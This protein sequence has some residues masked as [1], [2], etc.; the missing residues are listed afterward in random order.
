MA[1]LPLLDKLA[2]ALNKLGISTFMKYSKVHNS[3]AI[4]Q[5]MTVG[6]NRSQ[7]CLLYVTDKYL[8]DAYRTMEIQQILSKTKRFSTDMLILLEDEALQGHIPDDLKSFTKTQFSEQLLE[9]ELFT[10]LL[11]DKILTDPSA[12]LS[13]LPKDNI[14]YGSALGYFYGFLRLVL[15]NFRKRLFEDALGNDPA[16]QQNS[17]SKMLI[18]MPE[19][20]FCAI[21]LEWAGLIEHTNK[22][23]V[24][25]AN[26]AGN[27]Q[28]DYKSSLYQI[29]DP[30]NSQLYYFVGELATPLLTMFEMYDFQLAGMTK[31]QLYMERDAFYFALK[32]ILSHPDNR[33]CNNEFRLLYWKD[34]P[35]QCHDI[36]KYVDMENSENGSQLKETYAKELHAFL[37]PVIRDEVAI[38]KKNIGNGFETLDRAFVSRPNRTF[39]PVFVPGHHPGAIYDSL[40]LNS[41]PMGQ[42]SQRQV[43]DHEH[44]QLP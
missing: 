39:Q 30:E 20:C 6:I 43:L 2:K 17:V 35:A 44:C 29:H 36:S 7:K 25:V 27:K 1:D 24:R 16:I 12:V 21:G 11:A 38:T 8:G 22:F 31:D 18:I 14:G 28:R 15:P 23:V 19:S 34:P 3:D 32:A 4:S 41:Y 40:F 26:R 42:T 33:D 13:V 37:L 9:D 10:N 5:I